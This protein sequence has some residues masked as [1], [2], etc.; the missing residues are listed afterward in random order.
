MIT[1]DQ[2]TEAKRLF[3]RSFYA[4]FVEEQI[5]EFFVKIMDKVRGNMHYSTVRETEYQTSSSV[6]SNPSG[7]ERSSNYLAS[8][9]VTSHP[10]GLNSSDSE[11]SLS[12]LPKRKQ[13]NLII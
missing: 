7:N 1:E 6:S 10:V 13:R 12:L 3:G 2:R 5:P 9:P 4:T 11:S 8:I